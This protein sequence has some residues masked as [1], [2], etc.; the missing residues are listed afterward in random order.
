MTSSATPLGMKTGFRVLPEAAVYVAMSYIGLCAYILLL[1]LTPADLTIIRFFTW[2][3]LPFALYVGLALSIV[4]RLPFTGTIVVIGVLG[5]TFRLAAGVYMYSSVIDH[6]EFGSLFIK[7]DRYFFDWAI[8]ILESPDLATSIKQA[9]QSNN[10]QIGPALFNMIPIRI[11]GPD[12]RNVIAFTSVFGAISILL[13]YRLALY[14]VSPRL[15]LLAAFF[16][17]LYPQQVY[18]AASMQ[19]DL[20]L[21]IGYLIAGL[22][23]MEIQKRILLK[24]AWLSL[25]WWLLLTV[26][27]V[28]IWRF[29]YALGLAALIL[30]FFSVAIPRHRLLLLVIGGIG[31][32]ML[33]VVSS[34][35]TRSGTLQMLLTN[36]FEG[37][38]LRQSRVLAEANTVGFLQS[39]AGP[40]RLLMLPI[41]FALAI[42][43]G[44]GPYQGLPNN[45][46]VQIGHIWFWLPLVFPMLVGA[47]SVWK[48]HRRGWFILWAIPLLILLMSALTYQ[49]LISRYRSAAE[50]FMI[51]LAMIGLQLLGK[52][53]KP[54]WFAVIVGCTLFLWV[55]WIDNM[56]YPVLFVLLSSLVSIFMYLFVASVVSHKQTS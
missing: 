48:H 47:L 13:G 14:F 28:M 19:R 3:I 8:Q 50:P 38:S 44:F 12:P 17:A 55:I 16:L 21:V 33:I 39:A 22:M 36:P 43:F 15:A 54:Y 34:T 46:F 45:D 53:L 56:A 1:V 4:R 2:G 6:G 18:L 30:V 25:V 11:F 42:V 49:G 26:F 31:L 7:D 23:L 27:L 35:S 52:W 51:I 37:F 10:T 5:L 40:A 41:T 24:E 29:V 9:I 32:G 20:F